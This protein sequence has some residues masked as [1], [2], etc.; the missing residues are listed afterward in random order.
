MDST[1]TNFRLALISLREVRAA[2]DETAQALTEL[3]DGV[4]KGFAA[5]GEAHQKV[6]V[7]LDAAIGAMEHIAET[8]V[9]TQKQLRDHEERIRR[10]EEAS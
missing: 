4:A 5:V 8:S 10:L 3:A 2:Q 9:Q 1:E 7:K 6:S